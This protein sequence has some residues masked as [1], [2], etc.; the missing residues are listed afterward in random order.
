M[1]DITDIRCAT[2]YWASPI[3]EDGLVECKR[4]PPEVFSVGG[5]LIEHRPRIH[6]DDRCGEHCERGG[7]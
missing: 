4:F 2:C 3:D 5:K 7:R 6:P 1:E